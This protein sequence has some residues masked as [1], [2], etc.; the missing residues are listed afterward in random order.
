M[1]DLE[2]YSELGDRQ[3][4]LERATLSREEWLDKNSL[5]GIARDL[6]DSTDE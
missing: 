5:T 6:S 4:R 2:T 1:F 3:Q